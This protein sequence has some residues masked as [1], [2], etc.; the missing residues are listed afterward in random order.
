MVSKES[1]NARRLARHK[2]MRNRI[3]GT[4]ERPDVV[5]SKLLE[6]RIAII[7]DGTPVVATVPFLFS[8]NLLH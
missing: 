6:G 2:R 4:T 8:E 7:V 1:S 5:A 3:S